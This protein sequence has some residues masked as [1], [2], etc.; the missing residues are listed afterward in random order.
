MNTSG[1]LRLDRAAFML[2]KDSSV[3]L[4]AT[5]VPEG[6]SV[7][8]TSENPQTALVHQDGTVTAVSEG[9]AV[10][11][12]VARSLTDDSVRAEAR[13]LAS[14]GY[15][16][17]N[18]Y[19]PTS[20]G[21]FIADG[22]PHVFDGRMYVYGSR[23]CPNG[24]LE[25]APKKDWCSDD[26]HVIWSEDLIHW[27]DA[28][29]GISIKDIPEEIRGTGTRLWAPDL[30]K[31]PKD[32]RYYLVFCSNGA[33]VFIAESDSPTG[34]FG[35]VKPI[36]TGGEPV[37][38]IDPAVLADDDGKVYIALPRAFFIAQ[39]DQSDYSNILPETKVALKPI[40]D[41]ADPD[42]YPFEGPS[43]RKRGEL[44]YYIYIASRK[45]EKV[46]TRM[47]Y[48]VSGKPL[49]FASWRY[50]GYFIETRDFIRAGN[51]HG[52]FCEF[53]G[54]CYLS[55]HRMAPGYERFTRM[56]NLDRL[57]FG[58]DGLAREVIRTSSGAKGAFKAG[59]TIQAASACV[60][61]GGR[62]DDR[63]VRDDGAVYAHVRLSADAWTGFRYVQMGDGADAVEI[64][65]RSPKAAEVMLTLVDGADVSSAVLA[66][67]ASGPDNTWVTARCPLKACAKRAEV[68]FALTSQTQ[69]DLLW[70]CF[71]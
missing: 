27:V 1:D 12:A 67:P 2:D 47:D 39:L 24:C 21:L 64:C 32:G 30:F 69:T 66:L 35:N 62:V 34:P 8:W 31:G 13:C 58:P 29:V 45:N 41:A 65:Y 19:L 46:P 52:S 71:R 14:V 23:D 54:A 20:W 36:R 37:K 49:D 51:V 63:F 16:G 17:Q 3:R 42:Y 26:Y 18:P 28:G 15:A 40:I 5:A 11:R 9:D 25:G 4:R 7:S 53:H 48:L 60:F 56:M 6:C 70:F 50:G 57:E 10:I 33:D 59:E 68:R 61:S 43:L 55:Y 44:Y 38:C 22:E